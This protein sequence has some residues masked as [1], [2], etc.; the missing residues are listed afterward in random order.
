M[1]VEDGKWGGNPCNMT[2]L[3]VA[4]VHEVRAKPKASLLFPLP[5]W[6]LGPGIQKFQNGEDGFLTECFMVC[7]FSSLLLLPY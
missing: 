1:P 7:G 5:A 4:F 3:C 2:C 6:E